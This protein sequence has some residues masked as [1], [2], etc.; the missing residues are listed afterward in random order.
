MLELGCRRPVPAARRPGP[1]KSVTVTVSTRS[2]VIA[3]AEKRRWIGQRQARIGHE[4]QLGGRGEGVKSPR[5]FRREIDLEVVSRFVERAWLNTQPLV[6]G[7]TSTGFGSSRSK[8]TVR[9]NRRRS[10]TVGCR[11]VIAPARLQILAANPINCGGWFWK[12]VFTPVSSTVTALVTLVAKRASEGSV[13]MA[14]RTG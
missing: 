7:V 13:R 5:T 14:N 4:P 6:M 11:E 12:E 2:R 1:V 3:L 10:R 9:Q 8:V